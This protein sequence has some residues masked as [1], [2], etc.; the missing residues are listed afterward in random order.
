MKF[1]V[2]LLAALPFG[3][4]L[5]AHVVVD[6]PKPLEINLNIS[7]HL[8]IVIQ[9][10]RQ[11]LENITGEKPTNV[12]RPEDIGLPASPAG[13]KG[14]AL[15][16][17]QP[18]DALFPVVFHSHAT[19]RSAMPERLFTVAVTD[20]LKA[21]MKARDAQLRPL[22]DDGSIGESHTGLL[23]AKGNLTPAQSKLMDAENADRKALYDAEAKDKKTTADE[24]ALGYYVARLGYAKNGAWYEKR[25]TTSGVWEWKQWGK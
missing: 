12:V 8:D 10:A 19:S 24:V 17:A 20:D 11:D 18:T 1:P 2:I 6:Q 14:A 7:G 25:N 23:V 21:A 4:C 9:D 15:V 22:W 5:E 3:G 16:P 13:N